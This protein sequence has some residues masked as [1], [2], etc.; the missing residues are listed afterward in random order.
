M[1]S[2]CGSSSTTENT[3][4]AFCSCARSRPDRSR[5]TKGGLNAI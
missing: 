5:A 3:R 4:R 2:T 1:R